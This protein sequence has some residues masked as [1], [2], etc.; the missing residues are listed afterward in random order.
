MY[1]GEL[2]AW[3][4]LFP[5]LA[6]RCR[7]SWIHAAGCALI[8]RAG[9]PLPRD[10]RG[11]DPLC[12]CGRGKSVEGMRDVGADP[13]WRTLAPFVTRIAISPLFGV[14]YVE[15]IFNIDATNDDDNDGG[16]RGN[17]SDGVCENCHQ[18]REVSELQRCSR[19]KKVTYC[20]EK[21][22]KAHWKLHKPSCW[23]A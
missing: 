7:T 9:A 12:A 3:K 10:V 17:A 2:R 4:Q 6:E 11:L 18:E 23:P 22:Q 16:S 19:C 20:S 8:A 13:R 1:A 5:A 14:S 21:C 15:P